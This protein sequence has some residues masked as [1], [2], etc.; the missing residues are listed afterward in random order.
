MKKTISTMVCCFTLVVFA[1]PILAQATAEDHIR[2][3]KSLLHNRDLDGAIASL[4]KAIELK[5]DFAEAYVQRNRLHMLKG[6][7]DSALADLDKALLIDPEMKQA[8]AERG[9]IRMLKNDMKGALNDLD[10]AVGRGYRSDEVYSSRANLRMMTRD[11]QG[12]IS[13][14]NIAISMNPARIGYYL[15]R[16]AARS[17]TGDDDGALVDYT[18]IIEKFEQ[19]ERER[20]EAGKSERQAAPFDFTSPVISGPES[21]TRKEGTSTTGKTVQEVKRTETVVTMKM[22][23]G[24]GMTVERMEYL[25]NVAGAYMNRG[26]IHSK[27]GDSDAAIADLSKSITIHPF[28]AAYFDRGKQFRKRGDLSAAIA[29][30]TKAIE[31]RPTMAMFYLERGLTLLQAGKGDEAE[32]DFAQTLA[33]DPRLKTAVETRRVE[34]QGLREN[35]SP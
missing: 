19:Q 1:P 31:L 34:A 2:T 11:Y 28:F 15:G 35:K 18:S 30:F 32:K 21:S 24:P 25:P 9:R 8:Y 3:S 10:N 5:P 29:D 26:S 6:S 20:R 17:G 27:R 12:A 4:D 22:N 23:T 33:L 13:D 16:G 14:F 7:L